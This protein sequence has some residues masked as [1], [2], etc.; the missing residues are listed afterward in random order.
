[1]SEETRREELR[2]FIGRMY[3]ESLAYK[4]WR[5]ISRALSRF[6]GLGNQDVPL[7]LSSFFAIVLLVLG[8]TL[9]AWAFG[10]LSPFLWGKS[11]VLLVSFWLWLAVNLFDWQIK[12][13]LTAI[14]SQALDMLKLDQGELEVLK[15]VRF[16]SSHRLH[17]LF[18]IIYFVLLPVGWAIGMGF[19]FSQPLSWALLLHFVLGLG[20]IT[21]HIV[22]IGLL[23]IFYAFHFRL[24]SFRL[25]QDNPAGTV[26]LQILHRCSAQF[27]LVSALVAAI[28]IPIGL[29]AKMLTS[30][31]L[32]LSVILLWIPLLAFYITTERGFSYHI[33]MAKNNRISELQEQIARLENS[34]KIPDVETAETIQR[35][36]EIHE[37]VRRT[38]NSL[39][40]VESLVNLFSS[41]AL[42]M[43]GGLVKLYEMWKQFL[44][45]P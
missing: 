4:F 24:W 32:I 30:L 35:L 8:S 16:G 10:V 28:A 11:Y 17:I 43:L 40:N 31:T 5:G 41:L 38:P 2:Q 6:P 42:P 19:D 25:F 37:G 22:W 1:M 34:T 21:P 14:Q 13:S 29:F 9:F 26:S 18:A 12:K 44:G 45:I 36:L 27:L 7:W 15:W 3:D 33:Q 20:L 39:V 23:I